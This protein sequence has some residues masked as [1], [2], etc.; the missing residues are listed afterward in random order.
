[1]SLLTADTVECELILECVALFTLHHL[2][3]K[4]Q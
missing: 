2:R 1:V 4:D 3:R